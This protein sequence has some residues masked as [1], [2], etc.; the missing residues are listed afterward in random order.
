MPSGLVQWQDTYYCKVG[1]EMWGSSTSDPQSDPLG[2]AL[3]RKG[4]GY[5]LREKSREIFKGLQREIIYNCSHETDN[6]GRVC[7]T[8]TQNG[9]VKWK[10]DLTTGFS[11]LYCKIA[12]FKSG[13]VLIDKSLFKHPAVPMAWY[14]HVWMEHIGYNGTRP[15]MLPFSSYELAVKLRHT[16]ARWLS[17]LLGNISLPPQNCLHVLQH[18]AQPYR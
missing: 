11:A 4:S 8:R 3:N 5:L 9:L 13:D 7:T 6:R 1:V 18:L 16:Y 15:S 10:L 14:D 17:L 2:R 12:L